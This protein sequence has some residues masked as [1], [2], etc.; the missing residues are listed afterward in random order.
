MSQVFHCLTLN[1]KAKRENSHKGHVMHL[2]SVNKH[3][4]DF[5]PRRDGNRQCEIFHRITS[6]MDLWAGS[7]CY[8]MSL[9]PTLSV[10]L[11]YAFLSGVSAAQRLLS[12]TMLAGRTLPVVAEPRPCDAWHLYNISRVTAH[13]RHDGTEWKGAGQGSGQ[14]LNFNRREE[15]TGQVVLRYASSANGRL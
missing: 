14:I 6:Q 4:K 10:R 7:F 5:V 9:S 13:G 11:H 3:T 8:R 2:D 1:I 15:S 12:A